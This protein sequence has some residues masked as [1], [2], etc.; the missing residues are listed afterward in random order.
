MYTN[1]AL[2]SDITKWPVD[3]QWK[4]FSKAIGQIVDRYIIVDEFASAQPQSAVSKSQKSS[5]L[6]QNP[7]ISR[8]T[9][10]HSY[11]STTSSSTRS[12]PTPWQV[13]STAGSESQRSSSLEQNQST[14]VKNHCRAFILFSN[15]FI[16]E[17][18]VLPKH[19]LYPHLRDNKNLRIGTCHMDNFISRSTTCFPWCTQG[20]TR[21]CFLTMPLLYL[22]MDDYY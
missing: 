17:H 4:T 9:V 6:E 5:S 21:W 14:R 3:R 19:N 12:E 15:M 16:H 18:R 7:H 11:Y 8:I 2:P 22:M 1:N 13:V 20:L 10:E